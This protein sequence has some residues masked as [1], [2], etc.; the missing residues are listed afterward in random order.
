MK[1]NNKQFFDDININ[2]PYNI[3]NEMRSINNSDDIDINIYKKNAKNIDNR[4]NMIILIS[5]I[6]LIINMNY[7]SNLYCNIIFM[8][9]TINFIISTYFYS[10]IMFLLYNIYYCIITIICICLVI[11]KL[12]KND[13]F[14]IIIYNLF[15]IFVYFIYK[16]I[17]LIILIFTYNLIPNNKNN[18]RKYI[19]SNKVVSV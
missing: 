13:G 4:L 5:I 15:E 19:T 14:Y 7:I 18:L 12:I 17:S 2:N 8:L 10:K 9:I 1:S 3:N 6:D 11:N 16:I